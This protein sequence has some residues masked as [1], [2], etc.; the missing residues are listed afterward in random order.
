[1]SADSWSP[2]DPVAGPGL[3]SHATTD[4][5]EGDR[6]MTICNAC[7]YCEGLCAVFPAMERR[8]V[9]GDADLD[10]LANLCHNCG[11]CL[12]D[13]QYAPPH[14]FAVSVPSNL[15]RLRTE[16][17]TR[18]AWPAHLAGFFARNALLMTV[19][20]IVAVAGFLV[21]VSTSMG[22]AF[23]EVHTGEGA[24]YEVV[25]HGV[26]VALFVA[27]FAYGVG[28]LLLSVRRYWRA[29]GGGPLRLSHLAAAGKSA[30]TLEYLDGGGVGCMNA[31]EHPD[32]TRRFYHHLTY[33][34]FAACLAATT[35][36]AVLE[37]G[38]GSTAPYAWYHPVVVLGVIGGLGL[39]VGP[40]GLLK[41]KQE[42]DVDLTD[43]GSRSMEVAFL[44]ML[45]LLSATG[46]GVLILR[47]TVV[48][49]L[50]LAIHLG[51]VFAFFVTMPYGKF[52][53]GFYRYAALV[54]DRQERAG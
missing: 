16:T 47:A 30:N 42:R 11:A 6:L 43:P 51:V 31:D 15:A 39:L 37:S 26:I 40:A 9:F 3:L 35:L 18:Y 44:A 38:L 53:H 23:F 14:E 36:A 32:D 28:A 12:H 54:K 50:L 4:L 49:P 27:A 52:V 10:F 41:A 5:A 29:I 24:F 48:M 17:W 7:R 21:A 1:M 22:S 19:A 33:Y 45:M 46:F 2:R 8:R 34:G 20:V 25:P 13:C